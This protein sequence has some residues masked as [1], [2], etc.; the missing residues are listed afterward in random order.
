MSEGIGGTGIYKQSF[1]F[2]Q[3]SQTHLHS[4]TQSRGQHQIHN[5]QEQGYSKGQG[6]ADLNNFL[7]AYSSNLVSILQSK[8]NWVTSYSSLCY[9][10]VYIYYFY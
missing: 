10:K 6:Q 3:T 4:Q 5:Q 8:S 7:P 1:A 9:N 2:S